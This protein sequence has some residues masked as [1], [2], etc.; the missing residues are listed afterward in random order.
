MDAL[1][2][3]MVSMFVVPMLEIHAIDYEQRG[4]HFGAEYSVNKNYLLNETCIE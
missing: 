3:D 1:S 2:W 4:A